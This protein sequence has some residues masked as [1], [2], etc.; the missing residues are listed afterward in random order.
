MLEALGVG[1]PLVAT[2]VG[3]EGL[4]VADGVHLLVRDDPQAFADGVAELLEDRERA[5]ALARAGRELVVARYDWDV[6]AEL[7]HRSL[8]RW[9]S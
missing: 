4:D 5:A 8:R 1:R 2:S 6:L 9:L 7:L 3:A